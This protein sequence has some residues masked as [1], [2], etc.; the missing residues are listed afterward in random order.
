[1]ERL[2]P[3]LD[4]EPDLREVKAK[5]YKNP[6]WHTQQYTL[7][8]KPRSAQHSIFYLPLD[9]LNTSLRASYPSVTNCP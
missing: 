5:V 3:F 1:M 7:D 4:A 6:A 2:S 9:R 8:L